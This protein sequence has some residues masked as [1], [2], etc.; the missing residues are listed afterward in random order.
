[1]DS[2]Q[3]K[4][5]LVIKRTRIFGSVFNA[6]IGF[7]TIFISIFLLLSGEVRLAIFGGILLLLAFFAY[8]LPLML[9][10]VI[11][12]DNFFILKYKFWSQTIK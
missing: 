1:M 10:S 5:I 3:E 7:L 11:F 12:Y 4:P 9:Q 2:N 6:F 8:I